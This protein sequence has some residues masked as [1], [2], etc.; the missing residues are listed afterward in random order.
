MSNMNYSSYGVLKK[1]GENLT[2]SIGGITVRFWNI[3]GIERDPNKTH[4]ITDFIIKG[5]NGRLLKVGVQTLIKG[6]FDVFCLFL[7][8]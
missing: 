2:E 7:P 5:M 4:V 6:F 8:I 1:I 3:F